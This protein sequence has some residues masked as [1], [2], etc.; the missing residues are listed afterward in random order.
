MSL[1]NRLWASAARYVK[2]LEGMDDPVGEHMVSLGQRVDKL[3]RAVDHL[4]RQ[5]PSR[6][7]GSVGARGSHK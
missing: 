3:E 4:E 5:L 2:V 1:L 7:A 6:A